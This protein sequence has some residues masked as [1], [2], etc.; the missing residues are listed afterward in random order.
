MVNGSQEPAAIV[1]NR[2]ETLETPRVVNAF[3]A[4]K[5]ADLE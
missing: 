2:S 5:S 1:A 4:L 3:V